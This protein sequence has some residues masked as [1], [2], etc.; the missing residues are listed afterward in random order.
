MGTS[1]KR[2]PSFRQLA[3]TIA[4]VSHGLKIENDLDGV[5]RDLDGRY[6]LTESADESRVIGA[7]STS[8]DRILEQILGLSAG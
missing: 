2:Y 3:T 1:Y 4:M 6:Y 5:L 7:V 8:E